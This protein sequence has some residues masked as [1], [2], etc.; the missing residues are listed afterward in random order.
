MLLTP[1]PRASRLEKTQWDYRSKLGTG[2]PKQQNKFLEATSADF[3]VRGGSPLSQALHEVPQGE[4]TR[5][6]SLWPSSLPILASEGTGAWANEIPT[7]SAGLWAAG[8]SVQ[9]LSGDSDM[10]AIWKSEILYLFSKPRLET[11]VLPFLSPPV[12]LQVCRA[13]PLPYILQLV[14][15]VPTPG[16]LHPAPNLPT[17][18]TSPPRRASS[19]SVTMLGLHLSP[20]CL[21]YSH[22]NRNPKQAYYLFSD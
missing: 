22:S 9:A 18:L 16:P 10:A 7:R 14:Q 2:E 12:R 17:H 15:A 19:E 6:T 11:L 20:G 1:S 21:G 3:R 13:L 8:L 4:V 5:P